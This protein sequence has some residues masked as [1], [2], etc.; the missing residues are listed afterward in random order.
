MLRVEDILAA[1]PP[2]P[3]ARRRSAGP[4]GPGGPA[5]AAEGDEAHRWRAK[6]ANQR[7][8][9]NG[10]R[11]RIKK[12]GTVQEFCNLATLRH[13]DTV[14]LGEAPSPVGGRG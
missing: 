10:L 6:Y 2:A 13:G 4:A 12:F 9:A 1:E 3:P 11:G 5:R 14:Q 7:R 8:V